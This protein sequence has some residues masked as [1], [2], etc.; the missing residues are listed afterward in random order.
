MLRIDPAHQP[1]QLLRPITLPLDAISISDPLL[2][3]TSLHNL[4]KPRVRWT[5]P[6]YRLANILPSLPP[7]LGP[8][9]GIR[10]KSY[11]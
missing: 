2:S 10:V 9:S 1:I 11:A 5:V 4:G 7:H 6:L 8:Q 3:P